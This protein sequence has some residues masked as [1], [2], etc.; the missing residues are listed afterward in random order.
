MEKSKLL[1]VFKTLSQEELKLLRKFVRSPYYNTNKEVIALC[2]YLVKV[3]PD[4]ETRK[5]ERSY[6]YKKVTGGKAFVDGKMRFIMTNLLSVLRQF[7]IQQSWENDR[8]LQQLELL[9]IYNDRHLD[10]L[11]QS[12][13]RDIRTG[14]DK[15]APQDENDFYL[16]YQIEQ[17]YHY[18]LMKAQQRDVEPNLQE[19][20]QRLLSF[21]LINQLKYY[22][23]MLSYQHLKH[24]DYQMHFE[25]YVFEY[26]SKN[27]EQHEPIIGAYYFT[28]MTL[29]DG[30]NEAHYKQLR[31]LLDTAREEMPTGLL[32]DIYTHARNYCIRRVNL[33]DTK[34]LKELFALYQMMLEQ[35]IL[36]DAEGHLSPNDYKNI[37][38][39][40]L[41]LG[42]YQ[43]VEEFIGVYRSKLQEHIRED[44]YHYCLA[45]LRF[46][47]QDFAEARDLLFQMDSREFFIMINTKRI[48]IQTYYELKQENLLEALLNSY[49]EFLRRRE[50][51]IR[52]Y[53]SNF[54][55]AVRHL[56]RI[57]PYDK[58]KV[59]ELAKQ[60]AQTKQL[61][62]RSW[63]LE[64]V[65][66]L[67]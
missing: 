29:T 49:Y 10:Q 55:L 12:T 38:A 57:N 39:N 15:Q 46:F 33:N 64:K 18:F 41:R 30:E 31:E 66:E 16:P 9:K 22:A 63:L 20:S 67:L 62:S 56:V 52:P 1:Q 44:Y 36:L 17:S 53:Y 54:V 60:F 47:Q 27:W 14:I 28:L 25:P 21:Y 51:A 35:S 5:I 65:N 19:V 48:L 32:P 23:S 2:D 37:V 45:E 61:V 8:L 59:K 6:V 43:W 58:K 4:F 26:L 42:E 11:F 3:A 50:F 24:I 40:G 7:L 34:Y 13:L